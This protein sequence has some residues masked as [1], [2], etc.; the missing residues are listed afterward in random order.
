MKK[1]NLKEKAKEAVKD[2]LGMIDTSVDARMYLNGKEYPV[3]TFS[4]Q[5][6]QSFDFKGEPQHEVR[7]GL[8]SVGL[9]QV[10]DEQLNYWMFHPDV[11]YSGTVVF[12]SFSRIANPVITIEFSEGRCVKYGKGINP[13]LSLNLMI[14]AKKIKINGMTHTNNP[15]K[16]K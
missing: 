12:A 6:H 15:S 14:S 11:Y 13:S 10:T 16:N 3:D 2:A 4:V 7:G 5:F 8:L 1:G 9:S